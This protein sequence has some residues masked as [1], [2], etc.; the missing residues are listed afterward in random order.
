VSEEPSREVSGAAE[1]GKEPVK[2]KI[3]QLGGTG[4][5]DRLLDAHQPVIVSAKEGKVSEAG[6]G[7]SDKTSD[8]E[9]ARMS[10]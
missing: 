7:V 8:L 2:G 6:L 10:R 9:R 4:R 3:S 1:K 5:E